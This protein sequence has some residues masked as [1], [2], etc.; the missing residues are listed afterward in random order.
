[1]LSKQEKAELSE[2]SLK[3]FGKKHTYEKILINGLKT[4]IKKT[5]NEE[6]PGGETKT[7]EVPDLTSSGAQQFERVYHTGESIKALMEQA[8]VERVRIQEM[9]ANMQDE[10]KKNEEE[11]RKRKDIAEEITG[12]AL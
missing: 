7:V 10:Q 3:V 6:T 4:L 9:I 12:S 1:M 8:L 5:I 11:T 2:L